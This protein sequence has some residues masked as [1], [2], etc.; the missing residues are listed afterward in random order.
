MAHLNWP[1]ENY[2]LMLKWEEKYAIL[3]I[4]LPVLKYLLWVL[5]I[6]REVAIGFLR[7][8]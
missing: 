7:L 2:L 3:I 8:H 5:S 4:I 1:S 6:N